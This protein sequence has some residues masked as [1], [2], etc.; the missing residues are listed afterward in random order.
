MKKFLGIM[1]L[2]LLIT[3]CILCFYKFCPTNT[4]I[5]NTRQLSKE[6]L[7]TKIVKLAKQIDDKH[8]E[9][10]GILFTLA[11]AMEMDDELTL[12]ILTTKYS[13]MI[14]RKYDDKRPR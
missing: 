14:V 2:L 13:E 4:Q 10:A 8:P 6:E 9:T 1:D 3:I 11:G 5:T 7:I 12:F